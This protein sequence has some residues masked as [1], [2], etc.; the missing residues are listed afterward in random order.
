MQNSGETRREDVESRPS[1]VMPR[2]GGASSIPETSRLEL[3]RLR[4]TG[5]SGQAGRWQRRADT[6]SSGLLHFARN[7]AESK[8]KRAPGL[9]KIQTI[10]L[11]SEPARVHNLH[12]R[13]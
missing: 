6:R 1:V 8:R 9:A 5:S 10:W 11:I 7:D 13:L 2:A 12:L 4:I 3:R